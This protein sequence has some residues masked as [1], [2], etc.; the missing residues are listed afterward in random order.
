MRPNAL[1]LLTVTA[2]GV[3]AATPRPAAENARAGVHT[4]P[5]AADDPTV[6]GAYF[7]PEV[8][9]LPPT[10][11][12]SA[13]GVRWMVQGRRFQV[14]SS[15]EVEGARERIDESATVVQVPS[16]LGGGFLFLRGDTILRAED[17][18]GDP[19]PIFVSSRPVADMF[20]GLDRMYLRARSG[21]HLAFD[22]ATGVPLDLG[23]WP[24]APAVGAYVALDAWRALALT[25]VRGVVATVDAGRTWTELAIPL[26][27]SSASA[28]RR[29]T[30][31]GE[32]VPA[33]QEGSAEG[34]LV[35]A[36]PS[37]EGRHEPPDCY[38]VSESLVVDL[39]SRCGDV[40][41]DRPP[42]A[43]DADLASISARASVTSRALRSAVIDGWP[44]VDG[45]AVF[46]EAGALSRVRLVDGARIES[47][48]IAG[49]EPLQHCHAVSLSRSEAPHAFGFVCSEASGPTSL[50]VYDDA[51]EEPRRVRKFATP[52]N[53][54]TGN[55]TWL[56][57]GDCDESASAPSTVC[58]GAASGPA[59][60]PVYTW[61]ERK[62]E[63]ADGAR[64]AITSR[65]RLAEISPDGGPGGS[66]QMVFVDKTGTVETHAIVLH[67]ATEATRKVVARSTWLDPF[68]ERRPG[69]LSGWLAADGTML[70]VEIDE[71]GAMRAGTYL[72]DLGL[73]FVAGRYGIGWT[74]GRRGYETTDGGMTWTPFEAPTA[75]SASRVRACGPAGCIAD[76]WLRVG[77]GEPGGASADPPRPTAV[78]VPRPFSS[79][80]LRLRCEVADGKPLPPPSSA[81]RFHAPEISR[82][83]RVIAVDLALDSD[84]ARS[85]GLALQPGLGWLGRGF[86][87]GPTSGDWD[88]V[89]RWV[90]RWSSPFDSHVR[91]SAIAH[92]PFREEDAARQLLAGG[93]GTTIVWSVSVAEDP[94]HALVIG[95][96]AGREPEVMAIDEGGN[97][98]AVHR[99]D[100]EPWGAI[101]GAIHASGAWFIVTSEDGNKGPGI[102]V[103]RADAV[104]A[105]RFAQVHRGA[106]VTS[107]ALRIARRIDGTAIGLVLDG[108]PSADR[109]TP[110]RWVVPV[111]I[112]SGEVGSPQRLGPADLVDRTTLGLC[113]EGEGLPWTVDIPWAAPHRV[114]LAASPEAHPVTLG[115][116]YARVRMSSERECIERLLG[117][118]NS[119]DEELAAVVSRPVLSDGPAQTRPTAQLA[120]IKHNQRASLRC[121]EDVR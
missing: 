16:R 12:V 27:A 71:T 36:R 21:A 61:S 107:T 45:T 34:F 33:T 96:A 19:R 48:P 13:A 92:A 117:E 8:V 49:D 81:G 22:A 114:E 37:T 84:G 66:P 85:A 104:G 98:V 83:D 57:R 121:V 24:T 10:A 74:A 109:S 39:L 100:G 20:V 70:G 112:E 76:G 111:Q 91:S 40:A 29:N 43:V 118:L 80:R 1:V 55:G 62:L 44:L 31:T 103:F 90:F 78:P 4:R 25:D 115:Q 72:R 95:R 17:W 63:G 52:R 58:V 41:N 106:W 47:R 105:R 73:P 99:V 94:S 108:E 54:S 42:P 53:V 3:H 26:L 9:T 82:V 60:G 87:W 11:S 97:P 59:D 110:T 86:A 50:F 7:R 51:R 30:L 120:L 79:S 15:G 65:G 93:R 5:T 88:G 38:F 35:R 6:R 75:L 68:E 64:L 18:L 32:L 101:A 56:I 113:G 67:D 116:A 69:V 89:G 46:V 14:L 102:V 23:P 2:C 77:W 28:V 119:A